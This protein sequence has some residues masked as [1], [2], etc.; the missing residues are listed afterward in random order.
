MGALENVL[1]SVVSTIIWVIAGLVALGEL[2][3]NLGPLIAGAGIAG[4]ALGF[5]AQQVVRDYLSGVFIVSEDQFGP[6]D[7]IDLQDVSGTVEA[8]SL[9]STKVRDVDGVLW[10][11]ANG[12]I[13]KVGNA[14]KGWSRSKLDV[15]VA[16]GTDLRRAMDVVQEVG[17]GLRADPDWEMDV[18]EPPDMW[19]IQHLAADGVTIRLVL[20]VRPGRQYAVTRELQLRIAERLEDEGIEIPFPQRTLWLRNP[21]DESALTGE[22]GA[23]DGEAPT[24]A[25]GDRGEDDGHREGVVLLGRHG[26]GLGRVLDVVGGQ[27]QRGQSLGGVADDDRLDVGPQRDPGL[28]LGLADLGQDG[29]GHLGDQGIA[30]ARVHDHLG[31]VGPGGAVDRALLPPGPDLFGDEGQERG[32]QAEEDA[33]GLL[34]RGPGRV[35]PRGVA[36]GVLVAVGPALDQLD[37]V[38][39]EPPE[40]RLGALE[41]PGVVVALEGRR[42]PR[43]PAWPGGRAWPGRRAR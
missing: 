34:E 20:K 29:A 43:R 39:A 7:T 41:G 24:S 13:L 3:I 42:W 30:V 12:E 31:R 22:P 40:E 19:G 33:E 21:E 36:G 1:G 2:N 38:V 16:Y 4:V 11:V 28:G 37:V 5:G 6:G 23:A 18:L 27:G 14:T 8:V 15:S 10:T 35:R 26:R 25:L 32:E 17:D 9:R